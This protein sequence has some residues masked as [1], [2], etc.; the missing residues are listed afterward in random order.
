MGLMD[1]TLS[2]F[3]N[4]PIYRK[5]HQNELTFR[6]LYAFSENYVLSLSHDEVVYGKGSMLRKM[7]GDEWRKFANLRLLYGYMFGHPGKKLLFMGNEFGQWNEWNH[8]TSLDWHLLEQNAR[9]KQLQ[10]WVRDL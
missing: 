3:S 7:P 8:D 9:H 6:G 5:F 2:Y 4:D 10:R 1:D